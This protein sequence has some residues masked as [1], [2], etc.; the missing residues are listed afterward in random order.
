MKR[1][2]KLAYRNPETRRRLRVAFIVLAF[3]C[4][5]L[6]S[7]VPQI[8]PEKPNFE[9]LSLDDALAQYKK[10]S[11]INTVLGIEYE[12][13]GGV[14]QGDGSLII[15]RDKLSLRINYLGF[16]QGEITEEKGEVKSKPK[17]DRNKSDLLVNGLKSS[18]FWWNI[19]DY[20]RTETDDSY[21]LR[22][23]TRKVVIDKQSLLPVEQTIELENGDE[24]VI[25]YGRPAQRLTEDGRGI[26]AD[27]PLGW[28]P[29]RLNI[30]LR[31]YVVR[32]TV[33]SYEIT[34]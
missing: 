23:N 24:L 1:S 34:R 19:N 15:S 8:Q 21:E 20:V 14:M 7:C 12:K 22:N 25:T 32:I 17:I 29:G 18:L 6:A 30:Q 9:R 31:N 11:S 4:L 16:L 33:K 2:N 10:I 28:Y 5:L 13:N 27:S 26:D 3:S